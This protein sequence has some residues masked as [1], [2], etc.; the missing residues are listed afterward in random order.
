MSEDQQSIEP[1]KEVVITPEDVNAAFDF[2]KHF[3]IPVLPGLQDAVTLFGQDP[4]FEN[5]EKLKLELCRAISETDHE[6][7]KDDM[8][9]KIVEECAGVTFDMQFDQDFEKTVTEKE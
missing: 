5:Q 1:K 8:F 4:S 6:A 7:F 2:W 3:N 9:S